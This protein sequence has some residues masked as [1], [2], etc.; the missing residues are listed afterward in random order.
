MNRSTKARL[1]RPLSPLWTIVALSVIVLGTIQIGH[2]ATS[3]SL[4]RPPLAHGDGPAYETIAFSLLQGKGFAFAWDDPEWK[5][6]Y[7]SRGGAQE[8]VHLKLD[9]EAGPTSSRPP[10]YPWVLSMLYRFF[11]REPNGFAAA[12]FFSAGCTALA[13]VMS[14][15]L[16]MMTA[17]RLNWSR[18]LMMFAGL[19]ALGFAA[20]DRTIRSYAV[21]FLTEPFAL[22][23]STLF[24]IVAIGWLRSRS[25]W[26]LAAAAI[27][28]AAMVLARSMLILWILGTLVLIALSAGGGKR[29]TSLLLF[30]TITLTLLLPWS[31]RNCLLHHRWLPLGTHGMNSL[32]GGYSNESLSDEGNWHP[33]PEARLR[34]ELSKQPDWS[35]KPSYERDAI[36]HDAASKSLRAWIGE[37]AASLPL[38]FGLRLKTHWGPY[39][40]KSLIWKL[41][42][43]CGFIVLLRHRLREAIWLV[44]LPVISSLTVMILYETGGRFLVPLY[45][46]LYA[47]AGIGVAAIIQSLY[48]RLYS[49]IT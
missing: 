9:K 20:F 13:G 10:L 19:C 17:S 25:L 48:R 32:M 42:I 35:A 29:A 15:A 28:F 36:V 23:L 47:V 2:V 4:Y 16:A 8:Y 39:F 12:R 14:V 1:F 26:L 21:D 30:A 38:L 49:A 40:G 34:T 33:E 24:I 3:D 6:P 7:Q 27:V 31:I 46:L 41:S 11:G 37:N 22:F 18:P 44:G 45:G 5:A 43:L